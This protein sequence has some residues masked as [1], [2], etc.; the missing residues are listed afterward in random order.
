MPRALSRRQSRENQAF[1]KAL[2]ATGNARLAALV[3]GVNRST[4]TKR[5]SKHPAFAAAWDAA[6]EQAHTRIETAPQA[7]LSPTGSSRSCGAQSRHSFESGR[8]ALRTQ[9]GEPVVVRTASGRL[10]IRRSPPGRMTP[11]A[12]QAFFGALSD[13]ANVR[14]S[15]AAAGFAHSSFYSR[16]RSNPA[17]E[18]EMKVALSIGY[19]RL[20]MALIERAAYDEA[21][22][23]DR[24]EVGWRERIAQNP[25]P[26]MTVHDALMLLTHHRRTMREGW[27]HRDH[28]HRVATNAE[29]KRALKA[30]LRKLH[31][32]KTGSWRMP[33]E[34]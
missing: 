21:D 16:M 5:R 11:A 32:Q 4:Y 12:E 18:R 2:R 19:D 26:P 10:Q 3:L 29:V 34:G 25:L 30:A 17:F 8:E 22:I 23:D 15:A 9:G 28:R 13:S 20:E 14:L 31:H 6:L 24:D 27:E 1:L 33:E 7:R